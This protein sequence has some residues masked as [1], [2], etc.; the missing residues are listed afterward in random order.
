[1]RS[2]ISPCSSSPATSAGSTSAARSRSTG[3]PTV[4]ISRTLTGAPPVTQAGPG[5]AGGPS[6]RRRRARRRGPGTA[7]RWPTGAGRAPCRRRGSA[8]TGHGGAG[9]PTP[10]AACSVSMW[11]NTASPGSRLQRED[12]EALRV[13]VDRRELGERAVGEPLGLAVEERPR[14]VPGP[15]VGA[16]DELQRRLHGTGSTGNHI[17]TF[18]WPST[19]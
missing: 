5:R 18:C 7:A 8:P 2:A 4:T 17:E 16:G 1:M 6:A 3:W 14:H 12:A 19:L 11:K 13:V 15:A 9:P 10:P